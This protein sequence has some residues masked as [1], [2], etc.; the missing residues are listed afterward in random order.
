M[1]AIHIHANGGPEVL[2]WTDVILPPP[3]PSEVRVRH[4]AVGLNFSDINVRSG[5]FYLTGVPTFPVTLGNE[6]AGVIESVGARVTDWHVGER[7]AYAGT[8]G[9]FF[10]NTGAYAQQRNLPTDCLV[11]LPNDI[12]DRQAAAMLLKGLTASVI[13]QVGF[14]KM[15]RKRVFRMAPLQHHFELKGWAETTIVVR[16]WLIAMLCAATVALFSSVA[17]VSRTLSEVGSILQRARHAAGRFAIV[18]AG[19]PISSIAA[20]GLS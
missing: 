17:S 8:G 15:T 18:T 6:A 4:T 13:I 11:R 16:F 5:G 7:V 2:E 9:L 1:K 19:M 3:E 12:S 14:F 20:A 10:E